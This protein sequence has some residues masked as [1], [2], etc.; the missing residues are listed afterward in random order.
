M[1]LLVYNLF[2]KTKT[3]FLLRRPLNF[4]LPYNIERIL[5]F[6]AAKEDKAEVAHI[7]RRVENEQTVQLPDKMF[8]KVFKLE[9]TLNHYKIWYVQCTVL[10][11]RNYSR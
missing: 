11:T 2:T 8:I 5:Y 3:Q 4:Q 10:L 1:I 7:I 9:L 6:L